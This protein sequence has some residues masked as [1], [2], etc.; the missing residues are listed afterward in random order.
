MKMKKLILFF[1]LLL[2]PVLFPA[3]EF[4]LRLW[5]G[6]APLAKGTAEHDIPTLS[7]F[8]P[9][10]VQAAVPPEWWPANDRTALLVVP[11]G[12]YGYMMDS[13][14]RGEVADFFRR[15]GIVVFVLKYRLG[16]D[17]FGAYRHPAMLY[18]VSRALRHI[19]S[20]AQKYGVNPRKIGVYGNS[21]GGHLAATLLTQFDGGDPES[22]DPV[23][24]VSSRPDFGILCCPVISMRDGL[25]HAASRKFLLGDAPSA[26]LQALLSADEQ[27]KANTPPCFIWHPFGDKSVPYQGSLAFA[28]ALTRKKIP[29]ELHIFERGGHGAGIW[30][31]SRVSSNTANSGEL[32][33]NWLIQNRFF[34]L[35]SKN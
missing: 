35:K 7:V 17:K 29:C 24:R 13:S 33:I 15:H 12:G 32:L 11:G 34:E 30:I 31:R 28:K 16:L 8:M 26:E 25:T 21:A 27:V 10:P 2:F 19:R 9:R 5:E 23:E 18:D 6:D 20:N 22:A 14:E 3:Q 1:G 4:T